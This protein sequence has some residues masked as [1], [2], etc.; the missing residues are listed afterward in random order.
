[1]GL[2][3]PTPTVTPGP[4]Y[5]SQNN[6]A[7]TAVDAHNHTSGNGVPIPSAG[8]SVNADLPFNSYNATL[9]RTTRYSSQGAPL[10]N[11]ADLG[12]VYVVSGNLYYN[13]GS[14]VPI[15]IT[16]GSAL[17]ASS[18][19]GIGGDYTTSGASVFYTSVDQTYHFTQAANQT[20]TMDGGPVIIR[21]NTVGSF[22]TTL[23]ASPSIGANYDLTLPASLPAS[24]KIV[25]IDASGNV[26]AVYDF[27]NIT[28]EVVTNLIRVKDLGISTAKIADDAVTTVKI[29]N[30][31][32]TAA[33]IV[34]NVALNGN[35]S[36]V[37]NFQVGTTTANLLNIGGGGGSNLQ[38][39]SGLYV[40]AALVQTG[41]GLFAPNG[42]ANTAIRGNN[43][44][45][46]G[47]VT[48][49]G[50][51]IGVATAGIAGSALRIL[52][53]SVVGGTGAIGSGGENI[54]ASRTG[55]G[56][57]QINFTVPFGGN[58]NAMATISG[59]A[60]GQK[61]VI[62]SGLST[63]AASIEVRLTT[64]GGGG[65]LIDQDFQFW[66]IGPR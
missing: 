43:A 47:V 27:D 12:C 36:S 14:G 42:T 63:T 10:A 33:K 11:P 40:G 62:V 49:S 9:L 26:G 22:G 34:N 21:N 7:F 5:A 39:V 19:G 20:A 30:Q 17:N 52:R 37:G 15:Q 13:N 6:T 1:M 38:V 46:L 32:V 24:Q 16:A 51:E 59:G 60:G 64:G 48:P 25:T 56:L 66:A 50:S 8:I 2:T 55:V 23:R 61:T 4:T 53:V 41:N 29:L 44:T 3:L 35:C 28:T 31:N 18:I 54:T 45:S 58:P 65:A 57:Y